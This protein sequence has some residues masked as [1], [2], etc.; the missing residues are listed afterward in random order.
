MKV[1]TLFLILFYILN[2]K[3]AQSHESYYDLFNAIIFHHD[4][5][6]EKIKGIHANTHIE[7]EELKKII[8]KINLEIKETNPLFFKDFNSKITSGNHFLIDAAIREARDT[9]L[10]SLDRMFHVN[11]FFNDLDMVAIR[12][13]PNGL[14]VAVTVVAAVVVHNAAAITAA[15]A[16]TVAVKVKVALDHVNPGSKLTYE[17]FIDSIATEYSSRKK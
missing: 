15:A 6:V 4:K 3:S 10:D 12:N 11:K 5:E 17:K 14:A 7:T 2:L 13:D 8:R 16:V 1:R 9:T